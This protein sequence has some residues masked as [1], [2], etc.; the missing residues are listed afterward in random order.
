MNFLLS[1]LDKVVKGTDDFPI[2][3]KLI[4]EENKRQLLLKKQIYPYEYMD[5]FER[6][7]RDSIAGEREVL[8]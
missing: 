7:G 4:T 1:G 5:S 3:E 2:M 6:F 8:L